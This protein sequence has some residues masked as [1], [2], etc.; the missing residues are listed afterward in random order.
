MPVY[1]HRPVPVLAKVPVLLALPVLVLQEVC[2]LVLV[3]QLV[4]PPAL[5]LLLVDHK[6]LAYRHH[7]VHLLQ[8]HHHSVRL[9]VL[10]HLQVL[11]IQIIPG[12]IMLPFQQ[13]IM[14][15]KYIILNKKN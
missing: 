8:F 4:C 12:V 2:L 13:M 5:L 7:L 9:Q 1:R 6:A 14:I 10:A 3:H 15:W 11:V